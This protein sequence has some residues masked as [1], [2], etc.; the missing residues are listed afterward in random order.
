[1]E[2]II[3]HADLNNCYAS[4]EC[5]LNPAL[6]GKAV[7]VCGSQEDR[8]GIVLAKNELAKSYGVKTGEVIWQAK[9]KCPDLTI[10]PPHYS[11]YLYYSRKVREIYYRYTDMIEPY[12]IDECWLD[13]TGSTMLFGSG[14]DIAYQIKETV[15][16]ELGLTVS[17]G[18]SF[19]KIFAKLG[20][21]MKKPDAVTVIEKDSFK[22]KIWGLPACEMIFVGRSTTLKLKK[23]GIN[24]LGDLAQSDPEFLK[25]VLGKN[26]YDLWIAA[27]GL[28][29][30][31][32]MHTDYRAPIKSVGHGITCNADLENEDEVWQI[33]L[34]LAEDVGKRLRDNHL[35]ASGVQISVKDENL[36]VKQFQ[37]PL[38]CYTQ[39]FLEL[40]Q[41]A[42]K[43]FKQN[44]NWNY[45]VRAITIRAIN[46]V[47]DGCPQQYGF[48]FS[49]KKHINGERI[50]RAVDGIRNRYGKSAVTVATL[51]MDM[52]VARDRT[53]AMMPSS[54]YR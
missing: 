38:P 11:E 47:S 42:I 36:Y 19:N 33:F 9:Q 27:N 26:G 53:P 52:K 32:V 46:L 23:Y 20:S 10:V 22:E 14:Y 43:L 31:R 30:S 5:M 16:S 48:F 25:F 6:K 51:L 13:V 18:V 39:N 50:D 17:V 28:D 2:R 49:P 12:G 54:M 15:K 8:H 37:A 24:T 34:E 29:V 35:A 44:Y 21:D 45:N 4:I 1:M 7:A 3:L 40:A 41:A